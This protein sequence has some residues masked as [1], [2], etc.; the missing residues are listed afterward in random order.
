MDVLLDDDTNIRI[1]P[2][3]EFPQ[4][5]G[6]GLDQRGIG[7]QHPRIPRGYLAIKGFD[8]IDGDS[9]LRPVLQS[10]LGIL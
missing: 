6:L 9:Y 8:I 10:K 7:M 4:T 5:P 2:Q 3:R 1:V